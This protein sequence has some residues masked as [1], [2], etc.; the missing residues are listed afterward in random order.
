M[1]LSTS[2]VF[3]RAAELRNFAGPF[4]GAGLKSG[5]IQSRGDVWVL[6]AP[7]PCGPIVLAL[8]T[9]SQRTPMIPFHSP[10]HKHH[11]VAATSANLLLT[12]YIV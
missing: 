6:A 12:L 11:Q 2:F 5:Y 4:T 1:Y 9:W 3:G 10:Q 8:Y 7:Q